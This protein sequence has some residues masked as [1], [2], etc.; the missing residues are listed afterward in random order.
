AAVPHRGRPGHERGALR[1]GGLIPSLLG[2]AGAVAASALWLPSLYKNLRFEDVGL[3]NFTDPAITGGTPTPREQLEP[4]IEQALSDM[5][6]W[7]TQTDESQYASTFLDTLTLYS[8]TPNVVVA[9]A[10]GLG[11]LSALGAV[12]LQGGVGHR[13]GGTVLRAARTSRTGGA[14]GITAGLGSTALTAAG[15]LALLVLIGAVISVLSAGV[16]SLALALLVHAG[17][18]ALLVVAAHAGS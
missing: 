18:V 16:P 9:L 13:F 10:L 1:L 17:L 4:Q 11:V 6:Q 3:E 8:I 12:V 14:L 5:G 15:A 2:G 7:V